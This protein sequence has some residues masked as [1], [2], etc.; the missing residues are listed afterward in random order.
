MNCYELLRPDGAATGIWA[1]GECHRPHAISWKGRMPASDTN[2]ES[3]ERCCVPRDC[4]YCGRPTEKDVFG[5][6]EWAHEECIPKIEPKPAHPSM[7][8]PYARL[9]YQKMSAISEDCWCAGWLM[10][11]EYT[12]WELIHSENHD[13][14]WRNVSGQDLEE[15]RVLSEHAGGWI[16]TGPAHEFTPQLLPFDAWRARFEEHNSTADDIRGEVDDFLDSKG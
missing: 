12:L 15:L 16:W 14:R 10:G 9:L 5:D 4:R 8:N 1:C 11:N 3:A 13:Y 2:R 7:A 6:Y